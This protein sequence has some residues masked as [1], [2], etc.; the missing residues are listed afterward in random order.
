M[1]LVMQTYQLKDKCRICLKIEIKS[2]RMEAEI[3][4]IRRWK[5]EGGKFKASIE[6]SE[7]I[8]R[9]LDRERTD[10]INDRKQ[11]ARYVEHAAE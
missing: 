10:L 2:R 6:K 9:D 1:K 7:H 3:D 4:R 5:R 11:R 8:I